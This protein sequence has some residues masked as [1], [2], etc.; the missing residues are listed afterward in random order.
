MGRPMTSK[1]GR[2]FQKL[3]RWTDDMNLDFRTFVGV[4]ALCERLLGHRFCSKIPSQEEDPRH[5]V[6]RAD[7]ESLDRKLLYLNPD[8]RICQILKGI[9]DL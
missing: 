6:E 1:E 4:G 2:E 8:P 9:R 5:E 3:I 7:F